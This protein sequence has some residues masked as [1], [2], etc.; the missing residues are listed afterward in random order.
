MGSR[1]G[2]VRFCRLLKNF[3]GPQIEVIPPCL[4]LRA[5]R[6]VQI[7]QSIRSNKGSYLFRATW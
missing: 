3:L 1:V 7:A 5:I 2:L 6:V 4:V